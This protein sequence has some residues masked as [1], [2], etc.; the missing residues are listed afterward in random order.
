M[1][2]YK[3]QNKVNGKIYIGQT[4]RTLK[5]RLSS[6]FFDECTMKYAFKKYKKEMF[7]ISIID[8]A[9]DFK[10][11]NEKEK[12]WIRFYNS[13]APNGY[14]LTK[15]G[16]SSK[17]RILRK[18]KER[19]KIFYSSLENEERVKFRFSNLNGGMLGKHHTEKSRDKISKA[20]KGKPKPEEFRIH[21]CGNKNPA[22][23]E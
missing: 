9:N 14:N 12:Y 4:I 15:G 23:T 19:S 17:K 5:E 16:G 22:I 1:I 18:E 11:L 13:Q 7:E 10:E 20:M 2:I 21:L 8:K 3:I 6:H